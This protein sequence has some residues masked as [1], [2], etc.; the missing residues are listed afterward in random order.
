MRLLFL[1]AGWLLAALPAWASLAADIEIDAARLHALAEHPQWQRL[2]HRPHDGGASQVLSDDY[3]LAPNGRED[4]LAELR[5]TLAAL[6]QPWREGDDG[7]ASCRFPA[8][9]HWL[10]RQLGWADAAE[11]ERRCVRLW[12]WLD[13]DRLRSASVSLVSG[14]F[15]NPASAFGHALLRFD[16][17]SGNATGGLSDLGIN[18][19]AMVPQHENMLFYIVRG[20]GGAYA[21][22]FSDRDFVE[23]DQVYARGENRDMWN[24]ELALDDWQLRLLAL[25]VYEIAGRKF[26]YYF[27]SRNCAWRL[28]ELLELV[29]PHGLRHGRDESWYIPVELF[30]RLERGGATPAYRALRF[31]PSAQRRLLTHLEQLD[32]Q[33]REA[34]DAALADDALT[35]PALLAPLGAEQQARVL[36]V[37]LDW[38]SWRNPESAHTGEYRRPV[39]IKQRVLQA[40]LALPAAETSLRSP[41]P[42]PSPAL[43]TAPMRWALGLQ[44]QDGTAAMSTLRW[45]AASFELNAYH[46]MDGGELQVM[47]LQL[48]LGRRSEV[49]AITALSVRKLNG[50]SVAVPEER[51]YAWQ[52]QVGAGRD[53]ADRLRP[54]ASAGLGQAANLGGLRA[55]GF[56]NLMLRANSWQA[57]IG[58]NL[59]LLWAWDNWRA[60]AD[61][62]RNRR[63]GERRLNIGLQHRLDAQQVV[64]LEF[65]RGPRSVLGVSWQLYR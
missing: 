7:H 41:A 8:R 24:Y 11:P 62:Q 2:M 3:F 46:G 1:L 42:L 27:L 43:G 12:R 58:P 22:G 34:F 14:Y 32:A 26:T 36:A 64:K 37:L 19:G 6:R 50:S 47:D 13:L 17:G 18:F 15:G 25:H 51:D 52:V 30:H 29:L 5:A 54:Q 20:L 65:E 16:T 63:L 23:H 45:T 33:E 21:A 40:R 10:A 59:G 56:V 9:R 53:A 44:H 57:G 39:L 38:C 61:W 4:A 35:L 28:A 60:S 31:T 48:R 55:Y 49:R